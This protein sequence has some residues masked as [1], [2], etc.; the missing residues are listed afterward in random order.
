MGFYRIPQKCGKGGKAGLFANDLDKDP[1]GAFPVKLTVKNP[2]PGAE[3]EPTG[4]HGHHHLPAHQ[5]A[6]EVGVGVVLGT[7]VAVLGVGFF[8][9]QLFQPLFEVLMQ[10][11]LVV[12]D[13]NG[14]GDVHGVDQAETFPDAGFRQ[15]GFDLGRDVKEGP[16]GG[17]AEGEFLAERLHFLAGESVSRAWRTTSA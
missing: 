7:I 5:S 10:A 16:A 12:I 17:G 2:L 14:G 3:I 6:L 8:R 9:G 4:G 13:E 11:G 1:L 15:G